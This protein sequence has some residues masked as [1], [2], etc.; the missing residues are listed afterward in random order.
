VPRDEQAPAAALAGRL[1][2]MSTSTVLIAG[3]SGVV[4]QAAAAHFA[5]LGG[6]RVIAVSRRAPRLPAK[7]GVE[8]LPVDLADGAACAR[9]LAGV[10]G[11]VTHVVYAALHEKPG[12]VKGWRDPDQMQANL[13]MARNLLEALLA[14]RAPLR[15]VSLMQGTKAYGV[16]LHPVAVPAREDT[17]RD[18]HDNFYWLQEDYLRVRAAEAGFAFTI[19]R[20]QLVFGDA[21]GAAMNL[22]PVIGVHAALCA[23]RGEA[24]PYPGGPSNILEATDAR[25]LARALAW[26]AQAETARNQVFNVT[27]GDVFVWR[28]LWPGIAEALGVATAADAPRSLARDLPGREAEW[29]AIVRAHGLA[30]PPLAELLGQSHHYADFCFGFHAREH[31]PPVIVSTIRIRQAGFHDCIDTAQ[32]F[33]D[34]FVRLREQRM[35][36]PLR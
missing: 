1:L 4:G 11:E 23:A 29:Q 12:L 36:P 33:R 35:L 26:A 18:P 24:M 16:H 3:A 21:L 5:A 10:A 34:W 6:W 9:A 20:P 2:V 30:A 32:M 22:I 8:H 25:L 19:L 14:H 31:P 17:P 27:N 28:N 13:A 7:L 15:H